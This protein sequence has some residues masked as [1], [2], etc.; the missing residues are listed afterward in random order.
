MLKIAFDAIEKFTVDR[1]MTFT[2]TMV[3]LQQKRRV[4]IW[5]AHKSDVDVF[6]VV[7]SLLVLSL[8]AFQEFV[9]I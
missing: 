8:K 5:F 3:T 7:G 9:L 4:I 2:I 1:Y 6:V